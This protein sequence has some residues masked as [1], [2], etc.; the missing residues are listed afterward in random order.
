MAGRFSEMKYSWIPFATLAVV[1]T[2]LP[3]QRIETHGG[4]PVVSPDGSHIAFVSNRDGG[5]GDVFVIASDGTSETQLTR[6]PEEAGNVQW[7]RDGKQVVFSRFASGASRIFA[8]GIDGKNEHEIGSVPGRGPV[9]SPDGKQ[10]VYM[11]GGS[12]TVTKLMVSGADGSGAHQINDGT[13]IA[14][15]NHWSPD[16]KSIAFASR[17]DPK[18]ELAVFVINSDGSDLR[19]ATHLAAGEGNAQWPVW[20]PDGRLLA[21]QVNKLK[22]KIAHIWIVEVATGEAHA[23]ALHGDPHLDETPSWFPDGKRIAFQSNRSGRMEVWVMNVDGSGQRQLT[24]AQDRLRPALKR[25]V[26]H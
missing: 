4:L 19:Q 9:F 25:H 8:I 23:L 15:N 26:I 21:F 3:A 11:A 7:D 2:N 24:G 6:T 1:L 16:G 12:W 20:S 22:E 10:L 5:E 18:S 13:S 17:K 14:W